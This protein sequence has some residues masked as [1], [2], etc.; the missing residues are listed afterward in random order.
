[1]L[2]LGT[3]A[4]ALAAAAAALLAHQLRTYALRAALLGLHH[5]G[6]QEQ[7]GCHIQGGIHKV[8]ACS[9]RGAWCGGL[10]H[11]EDGRP[12]ALLAACRW[13]AHLAGGRRE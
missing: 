13:H 1:M 5:A 10:C 4:A 6:L 3:P 7:E 8:G 12:S 11:R 9:S 2:A